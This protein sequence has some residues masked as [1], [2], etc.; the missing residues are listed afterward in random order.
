MRDDELMTTLIH[1]I[2]KMKYI[3]LITIFICFNSLANGQSL[4]EKHALIEN[5]DQV[6]E[7]VFY[8]D[9]IKR[10]PISKIGLERTFCYGT[11]PAYSILISKQGIVNYEGFGHVER[12]GVH[13]GKISPYYLR[14]LFTYI[15]N[16]SFFEMH[17]TYT[18]SVTDNPTSYTLVVKDGKE[19]II[20]N[21]ANSGPFELWSI[22]QHIDSL[23]S[24]IEWDSLKE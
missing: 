5:E 1:F 14:R 8:A 22:E 2:Y 15:E 3:I 24:K 17:D 18:D 10:S 12:Q 13:T 4:K 23:Y 6:F 20:K 21:Y 19:K 11:C 7:R 9:S 16:T